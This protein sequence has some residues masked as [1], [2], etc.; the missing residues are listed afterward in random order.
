LARNDA[1]DSSNLPGQ[2]PPKLSRYD[3]GMTLGAPIRHDKAWIFTSLEAVQESRGNIF[4]P[5]IPATLKAGED[6]SK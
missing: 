6:F 4:P 5:N 3:Y 2:E 1:L